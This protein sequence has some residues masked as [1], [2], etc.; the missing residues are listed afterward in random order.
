[1]PNASLVAASRGELDPKEIKDPLQS[2]Q[3]G[4]HAWLRQAAGI[5]RPHRYAIS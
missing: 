1:M 3:G 4:V 2:H 5:L